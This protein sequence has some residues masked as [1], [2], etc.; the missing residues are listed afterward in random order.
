VPYWLGLR[1]LKTRQLPQNNACGRRRP[2]RVLREAHV[3][4]RPSA[5]L[6]K[7]E[8]A[9]RPSSAGAL[10]D[11]T[12]LRTDDAG[13]ESWFV[14]L[15]EL[16]P[17]EPFGGRAGA[18]R[19]A[20]G[21]KYA[22]CLY[23]SQEDAEAVSHRRLSVLSRR[24]GPRPREKLIL[25]HTSSVEVTQVQ[26]GRGIKTGRTQLEVTTGGWWGTKWQL[27]PSTRRQLAHEVCTRW[28]ARLQDKI[29]NS[30]AVDQV[31][32]IRDACVRVRVR[33]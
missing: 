22:L 25:D 1:V 16:L 10:R 13:P 15:E 6:Q 33:V 20:S 14:Q 30:V 17:D 28:Y 3:L 27:E 29:A 24:K 12:K 31:R 23:R 2:A 18:A 19:S 4:V 7:C 32:V 26:A 8:L 9:C 5:N 11:S 21:H